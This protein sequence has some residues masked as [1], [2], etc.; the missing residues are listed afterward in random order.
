[1][2]RD[3]RAAQRLEKAIRAG[4]LAKLRELIAAG[5]DV[6]TAFDD[7]TTPIQVAGRECQIPIVR[8]LAKAGAPLVELEALS[9]KE[10]MQLAMKSSRDQL[11]DDDLIP[12][13][14]LSEWL[15]QSSLQMLAESMDDKMR[16][17]IAAS[18]GKLFRAVRTR[19][20]KLLKEL[21]DAPGGNL[22]PTA[23]VTAETPLTMAIRHRDLEIAAALVRAGANV[24]QPGFSTPL[25]FALPDLRLMKLLVAAGADANQ[26][27]MDI[28]TA[29][30]RAVRRAEN[31]TCS[32][33]SIL[34]VR[35]LLEGGAHPPEGDQVEGMLLSELE[36]GEAW[37]LYHEILPHYPDEVSGDHLEELRQ[38]FAYKKTDDGLY[39]LRGELNYAAS[40]GEIEALREALDR[41][42]GKDV[43]E[44]AGRA[45]IAAIG[46][47]NLVAARL[48]I[49]AGADLDL[50]TY[51]RRR[52][53]T[54]LA[55]AAESWHRRSKEAMRLLLDAGASVDGHNRRGVTALMYAVRVAYRHGAVLRKAVPMLLD[56]GADVGL[57]DE[58]GFTAWSLAKAPLIEDEERSR[59]ATNLPEDIVL[60]DGPDLSDL[61]SDAANE[62]D[63][64]KS[65]LD[66]C[67]QAL[68]LLE[69]AGSRPHR[70]AELR[71]LVAAAGGDD[72]RVAELLAAGADPDAQDLDGNSAIS[73][74]AR[75]GHHEVV[76]RLIDAGGNVEATKGGES[77]LEIAVRL[78][79]AEMTRRLLEAGANAFMLVTMSRDLLDEA[80]S[81][82]GAEAV[83]LVRDSLPPEATAFQHEAEAETAAEDLA[84]ESQQVLPGKAESGNLDKVRELLS[85]P[86][87]EVDG[88]DPLRRTA[89]MAASEAGHADIVRELIAAGADV[90]RCNNVVGSPRSTPLACAAI[91]PSAE[92]DSTLRLL[93][94]AGAD[95]D[96]LG[97]DGCTAL[98]HAVERDVGFFGRVGGPALSTRTLIEAGADLEI[99]D[100]YGLTAWM[101]ACSLITAIE[102]DE[103]A[104][105]YQSIADLLEDAG[106][107]TDG[108]PELDLIWATLADEID[109]AHSLLEA[110]A[111]PD[112]RR[113]DGATALM[114]AVRDGD[115]EFVRLLI[116]A[117]CDVDARQWIDRG[118]RAI[119]AA[120]SA[121]DQKTYQM[122]IAA[123]ATPPGPPGRPPDSPSPF[124]DE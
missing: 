82:G 104:D 94:E 60:F 113:F 43:S 19:D 9:L 26:R 5:A 117:G 31:P 44:P 24:N 45:L 67:R 119:D 34:L 53:S 80:E 54:A 25:S 77:A 14:E 3:K 68:E 64:R 33:D 98:M 92:R 2:K 90:N 16:A 63:R 76:A 86:G 42:Q 51:E 72:P 114:L 46:A 91:G 96:Q 122:L 23:P 108:Q 32:D 115:R 52:G 103:V 37:E 8:A 73:A 69:D 50:E 56:A 106:A 22:D 93:L 30:E 110:G 20:L 124:L 88:F 36:M 13:T 27:G 79:D 4:D 120:V 84:W 28:Q 105:Q 38:S 78:G 81:S 121:R 65:R 87:V 123:G 39:H 66:R 111:N 21:I 29:F 62:A 83:R 47:M 17:E 12:V 61:F 11:L 97:A 35:F 1:M 74:A 57:E 58:L 59:L 89:L 71:L 101:R 102:L 41:H 6:L 48:L 18:E 112:A 75:G 109:E 40:K 116:D 107:A 99:R 55:C 95:P 7:D 118:P 85:I 49:D 70:E 100:P 10:R 15:M